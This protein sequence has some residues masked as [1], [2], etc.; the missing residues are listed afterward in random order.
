MRK[1]KVFCKLKSLKI[2]I[3]HVGIETSSK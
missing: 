1:R 2:G 3:V